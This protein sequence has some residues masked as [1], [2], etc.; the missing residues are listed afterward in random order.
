MD[1]VIEPIEDRG[2]WE[3]N[4]N[5]KP[6]FI[7]RMLIEW[8][9]PVLWID[10]DGEI[11]QRPSIFETVEA[12]FAVCK[13]KGKLGFG[14]G[15]LYFTPRALLLVSLWCEYAARHPMEWDQRLL[16]RAWEALQAMQMEPTTEWLPPSYLQ[17]IDNPKGA[18]ILHHQ[19][20]R[21]TRR[22]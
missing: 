6:P 22:R 1:C 11:M 5:Q 3:L 8:D 16:Q 20:S 19:A 14:S 13:R 2:A 12:D 7:R 18:V 4:C 10:A 21:R 17:K 15:T 9:R